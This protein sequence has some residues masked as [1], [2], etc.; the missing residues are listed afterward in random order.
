MLKSLFHHKLILSNL[1]LLLSLQ[2]SYG[3]VILGS[4]SVEPNSTHTYSHYADDC[5]PVFPAWAVTGGTIV[6]TSVNGLDYS[7]TIDWGS[8]G[9]GNVAFKDKIFILHN[10]DVTIEIGSPPIPPAANTVLSN[11]NYIHTITPSTGVTNILS[12]TNDEKMENV[13][14]FDGL[15]RAKQNIAIKASPDKNDIIT[16]V[17]YDAFGRQA[18]DWL[19]Y[20]ES[21]G[22]LGSYRGD[23][24]L[25]TQQY[26]Q[27]NYADDFVGVTQTIDIN[28]YSE[29]E[30]EAS[31]LNRV[32]KQAA[33]GKDWKLGN[34]HEIEFEYA[35]NTNTEVNNF[36]VSLSYANNT[37]T[38]TLLLDETYGEN[39][40]YRSIVYDENYTTGLYHTTEEFKDKL[41]RVLLKRTY[42][43]VDINGD[44]DTNDAGEI[45]AAHDTYYVYDNYGNLTYVLP[46]KVDASTESLA[47]I[48]ANLNEL[49]YQYKYDKR[50]RLVEKKIPGKGWES[51]VYNLTDQPVL[52]Q[53][54]VLD[55]QNKWLFTKYDAYGRVAYSGIKDVS[56]S[57]EDFQT[58]ADNPVT[59][60]QF[61]KQESSYTTL[62][63]VKLY[64]SN[65]AIPTT[66]T[67]ITTVNYYDNYD[68]L[69]S[70]TS[71]SVPS[72]NIYSD[73]IITNIKGLAS[74][75][76]IKVLETS[77]WITTVTGYDE[78]NRPI[79]VYSQ[80]DYLGT[81]DI[82][83]SKLDFLGNVL[84][85]TTTHQKTGEDDI[86]VEDKFTYDHVGRLTEQTHTIDSGTE[87]V[88]VQN[89][90]DDLGQFESKGV[91]GDTTQVRL[92]T[93]D[94][95]YNVRGW[96]KQI[97]DVNN[98]GSDLFAFNINYNDIADT[99]KKLYNGN[100]SQT[101]WRTANT[102][103]NLKD[104]EYTYDAL[105]RITSAVDNTNNYNLNSVTY[106][107]MGNIL[108]LSRNGWQDTSSFI[109]KDVL[110]Y[111]YHNN[112]VSNKLQ[113]VSDSGNG[114]YGF[115]DGANQT[116][117]YTYDANANLI[118]DANKGITSILYNHLNL[119][120]EIKFDNSNTKKINYFY[121]ADATKLRKVT[122]DSGAITTTD[123]A[124]NFKYENNTLQFFNHP[125][126]YV[127]NDNGAFKYV[128]QYKDHLGSIRL[129]Y[130]DGDGNGSV[131]Q[132]E[133][134][135]ENHYYPYGLKMRGFNTGVSSLGNS[136]A[137]KY[138]FNGME[139]DESFETLNT[140]DFGA[141]N[142]DPALGRWMNLDPLTEDMTRFSPYN[143][144]FG[145]P[146]YYIDPDGMAPDDNYTIKSD[147]TIYVEKT[148]DK[149][150]T[151]TYVDEG[152]A[153][154]NIG[155][156]D[157]NDSG[158]IQT[159]TIG[160]ESGNTMVS[161]ST[162]EGN[163]DRQFISGTSLSSLIG[164]SADS[165]EEISVVSVSNSDGTSPSPSTSHKNGKNLDIRYA[166][167]NGS[168]SA[169]NYKD[170]KTNF[171]KIDPKSSGSMNAS[172]KKFGY[173]DIRSST[174]TVS[175]TT[176][177]KNGKSTTTSTSYS[178]PGTKNL[179]NHYD[180]EHLQGYR[181][182][183]KNS[184]KRASTINTTIR[185][186][187]F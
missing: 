31:P 173:K 78:K 175:N 178:V 142:Y 160:Y 11:E 152:G 60:D 113:N 37:Y 116:T 3:Q 157:K 183:L 42:A 12:L 117:E 101:L 137:Q 91:G 14:Y 16:H 156:Y 17:D 54:A 177:G 57:R 38:P 180:H 43:D 145:N 4:T 18:K 76:K 88:I 155:T 87:E 66:M 99:N 147:G 36:E 121:A 115:K 92:Q 141:R 59:Y 159:P 21:V 55:S 181:P 26:Y 129:S 108:S 65:D 7:V 13:T 46:P 24:S 86:V 166:G 104:Y 70:E 67:E 128:Y 30:L 163:E 168:R 132:S 10:M 73:S 106:D 51:I 45:A 138:K 124:G 39:E 135:E 33:P 126:G 111:G 20:Y 72:V 110:T 139:L 158:L 130:S 169:I 182:T 77:D 52:T 149:T 122:N 154:H 35:S 119:P 140:Y 15:G 179:K 9:T 29:K 75:I 100:I 58:L 22:D 41:G 68:F 32:L 167:K 44:G 172:L 28:A 186:V 1:T 23:I 48:N 63:G 25:A 83:E 174:L 89:S 114:S 74:G 62:G 90:Y 162:K 146:V 148:N 81:T 27:T 185:G 79:W 8:V 105:N 153:S 103:S 47:T 5:F 144:A 98:I 50:N 164:A 150:D 96:L 34:G 118:T 71:I 151:F 95:T 187:S 170:S 171:D 125:E 94:Y 19:P 131:S 127:N 6:S 102:D 61:V 84:E 134:I 136:L 109:D 82:I 2:L 93:V 49:A 40:L 64:Y 176:T 85:S 133:I 112:E 165:G 56:K 107:K 120:T 97:N 143:Y 161:I 123:Y 69:G 53:D 80:N 184:R